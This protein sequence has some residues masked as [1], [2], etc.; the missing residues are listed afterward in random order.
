MV[1][2]TITSIEK[3]YCEALDA[4][5]AIE[6]EVNEAKNNSKPRKRID[7]ENARL[8]RLGE[9]MAKLRELRSFQPSPTQLRLE[10]ERKDQCRELRSSQPLPTQPSTRPAVAE[11]SSM[12]E[13]RTLMSRRSA[14]G[15]RADV[16]EDRE[17]HRQGRMVGHAA[18]LALK[19]LQEARRI[20]DVDLG[21]N[22]VRTPERILLEILGLP[23]TA[24]EQKRRSRYR[25]LT[26]LLHPNKVAWLHNASYRDQTI[27][28]DAYERLGTFAN[29]M[30]T[31]KPEQEVPARRRENGNNP[32]AHPYGPDEAY[33]WL[34]E[35]RMW[36]CRICG[37]RSGGRIGKLCTTDHLE[38]DRHQN[39]VNQVMRDGDPYWLQSSIVP[40]YDYTAVP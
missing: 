31:T 26:A 15:G 28:K 30:V 29:P 18:W 33:V 8:A 11:A 13:K 16:E 6:K 2:A 23:K 40:N 37:G 3:R 38:S 17:A 20:M 39:R 19:S 25:S 10:L 7:I 14:E 9:Q 34:S 5:D 24:T 4:V 35:P 32:D 22:Q 1:D 36:L 21:G 12:I 27:C